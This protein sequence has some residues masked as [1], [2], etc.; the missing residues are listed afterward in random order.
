MKTYKV[1]EKDEMVEILEKGNAEITDFY[2]YLNNFC[3]DVAVHWY[4]ETITDEEIAEA[5]ESDPEWSQLVK[6]RK[7]INDYLLSIGCKEDE[8]VYVD[9]TW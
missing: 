1:F 7:I 5:E 4:V 8:L 9:I 3:N 2:E 6:G